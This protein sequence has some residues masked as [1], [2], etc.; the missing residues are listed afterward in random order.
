MAADGGFVDPNCLLI[1]KIAV[2]IMLGRW[3][4]SIRVG[5]RIS[6]DRWFFAGISKMPYGAI[7]EP[8]VE[9]KIRSTNVLQRLARADA[10]ASAS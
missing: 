10:S 3:S 8:T 9:Y 5:E 2:G 4:Q 6:S 1:D 7:E